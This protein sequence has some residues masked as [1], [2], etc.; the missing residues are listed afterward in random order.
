V[1]AP[2]AE[3]AESPSAPPPDTRRAAPASTGSGGSLNSAAG[4]YVLSTQDTLEM[5]I[6]REPD[7]TSRSKIASDGTV[8]LP[9]IGDIKVA[10]LTI[11]A[12]RELIRKR[13]DTDYLVDPQVHLN[14]VDFAQRQ[15]TVVGQVQKPG[16]YAYPGGRNLSLIEAVGN[17]GGFTRSA[18]TS[19]VV[20][21]RTSESGVE[22][23]IIA[24]AKKQAGKDSGSFVILPGDVITVNESWW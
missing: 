14:L 11:R 16:T 5:T 10:G 3:A 2:R 8:Q 13:Y 18:K 6:Y 22:G 23:T 24:N 4:D 19:K 12:A 21:T 20:I 1:P 9:L 7:L 15:Y 17:A